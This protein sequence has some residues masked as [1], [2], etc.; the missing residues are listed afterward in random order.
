M[1]NNNVT[2][3]KQHKAMLF[4]AIKEDKLDIYKEK[5]TVITTEMHGEGVWFYVTSVKEYAP[6]A[7]YSLYY[8]QER[9]GE[10]NNV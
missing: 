4:R 2:I 6:F 7:M 9:Y 3:T 1:K 8:L 5:D 10:H